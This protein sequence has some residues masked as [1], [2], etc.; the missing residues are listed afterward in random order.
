MEHLLCTR[1]GTRCVK[2]T[3]SFEPYTSPWANITTAILEAWIWRL[4]KPSSCRET[5]GEGVAK[6]ALSAPNPSLNH[7]GAICSHHDNPVL[8]IIHI[9]VPVK[10]SSISTM[11]T[12]HRAVS[13]H[14][15]N[16]VSLV[17]FSL[18]FPTSIKVFSFIWGL[19][20]SKSSLRSNY[21]KFNKCFLRNYDNHQRS[22]RHNSCPNTFIQQQFTEHPF[23]C[24]AVLRHKQWN[25]VSGW[26][27]GSKRL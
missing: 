15:V 24:Q 27:T 26:L 14:G 11:C 13:N 20:N 9:L 18:N 2:N 6:L 25:S 21:E 10:Y 23:L 17:L 12:L 22:R 4:K 3:V 16:Q 5:H 19:L 1:H 8:V 7:I